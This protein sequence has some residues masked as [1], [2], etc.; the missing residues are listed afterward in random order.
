M[1]H[2]ETLIGEYLEW[3]GYFVV[4]NK[5]VGRLSHGGWTM[6]LDVIGYHPKT[7]SVV[8]YEP[9]TDADDWEK[10]EARFTKKMNAAKL[11]ISTEVL[12]HTKFTNIRH[13]AVLPSHPKSRDQI[14]G[15]ELQSIDELINEI[16]IEVSKVGKL[17]QSA[18]SENFPL[19]RTLQ[20]AIN[21]Y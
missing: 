4:K 2:L 5:K 16:K 17:R 13:I 19:L 11:F 10:R 21:G 3:Q 6:E 15:F 12:T 14:A 1:N 7:N 9:S 18:I 20:L 8:H